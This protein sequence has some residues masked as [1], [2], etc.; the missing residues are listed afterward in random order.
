MTDRPRPDFDLAYREGTPPWDIGRPQPAVERL[1]RD[2][3]LVG[4]IVDLGCG[5]GENALWLASLGCPVVGIDGSPTAI[6]LARRK[7][8]ERGVA[9]TFLVGDALDLGRIRRRFETAIDC[10][11]FHTFDPP[12]ARAY[13][14]SLCEVLSPGSTLHVLCFSDAEPPGPGPRRVREE[15]LGAA[16]R[17]IFATTRL[18]PSSFERL[19]GPPAKA[20]LARLVRI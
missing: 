13:A 7:A 1:W 12:R 9:A 3:E 16:F 14:Q 18:E 8:S 15:D 11:L 6:E 4:E 17:G 19:G 10:G 2:G 5:T 20:W